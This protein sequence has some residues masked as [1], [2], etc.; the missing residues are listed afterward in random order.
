[1]SRLHF[2]TFANPFGEESGSQLRALH[3]LQA[4]QRM[5]TV[6]LLV[7]NTSERPP[8]EIAAA[9]AIFPN[10]RFLHADEPDDPHVLQYLR[11][12]LSLNLHESH[13]TVCREM[14]EVHRSFRPD[15]LIWCFGIKAAG[16]LRLDG[17]SHP[18]FLDV[19]DIPSQVM[20]IDRTYLKGW[21]ERT[22][23]GAKVHQ[24]RMRE[25]RMLATYAG[26]GV[27]SEADRRY[28]GEHPSVHVIPNGFSA[29]TRL[30]LRRPATPV[31]IGFIGNMRYEPNA[32]G[33]NW[34]LRE[35][36]PRIKAV[37][38]DTRFRV[39]GSGSNKVNM[40][41]PDVDL[42]GYLKEPEGEVATWSMLVVPILVGGGT[43][44]K[45]ADAFSRKCP[46]VS[47]PL[48]AYG[49]NVAHGRE[50]LL[51]GSPDEF[52]TQC[53]RVVSRPDEAEQRAEAAYAKYLKEM[54]WDVTARHVEVAARAAL[55]KG[56]E[57]D[58]RAF[59]PA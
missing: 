20:A 48:G 12:N 58:T 15:D 54:T 43:R 51:A 55:L 11:R 34:F 29:P 28:L 32:Q 16:A 42:L 39:V 26:V 5:F 23:A 8:D 7:M 40:P 38:P 44:I 33:V 37:L 52:A 31:R 17:R 49:H 56:P 45:I 4:L 14:E 57:H 50:L 30:P 13:R 10:V 2:M 19:D 6:H 46:V 24:Y 27:C 47:T 22:V 1:M 3:I 25:R 36:W 59:A 9:R 53:L 18:T 35:V 21:R 41:T